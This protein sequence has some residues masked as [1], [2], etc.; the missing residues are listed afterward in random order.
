M[1][2]SLSQPLG[3]ESHSDCNDVAAY[4]APAKGLEGRELETKV[5][6]IIKDHQVFN[7]IQVLEMPLEYSSSLI[8][9][10]CKDGAEIQLFLCWLF[11]HDYFDV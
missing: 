3:A 8:G 9:L 7:Y 2:L 10:N 1:G 5:H 4:Y 11:I 6:D